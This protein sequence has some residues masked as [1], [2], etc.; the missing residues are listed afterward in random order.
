[1]DAK[2]SARRRGPALRRAALAVLAA[3]LTLWVG[4]PT[5]QARDPFDVF[6]SDF[7]K[8]RRAERAPAVARYVSADGA[9]S[10]VL[11]LTGP[12]PLLKYDDSDEILVLSA[13]PTARNDTIFKG[14]DGAVVL[15]RTAA[16]GVTWF[17]HARAG[18]APMALSRER[19]G[20]LTAPHTTPAML[21]VLADA[22][23]FRVYA[24]SGAD[25]RFDYAAFGPPL[26]AAARAAAAD[27]MRVAARALEAFAADPAGAAALADRVRVVSFVQGEAPSAK[28]ESGRLVILFDP[29][30]GPAGR[31][32]SGAIAA[33]LNQ[34][35]PPGE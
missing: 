31:P 18:G 26:D 32:S 27:A 19:P 4:A 6:R 16:G 5:S 7:V 22:S 21:Q 14:D 2:G 29:A 33:H 28:L 1:M 30:R 24:A 35:L 9:R 10:F 25:I 15:R 13:V 34:A 23:T 11:D 12:D 3:S 17:G 20:P 8:T